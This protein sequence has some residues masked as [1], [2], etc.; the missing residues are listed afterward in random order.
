MQDRIAS[1]IC[2]VVPV[3][4]SEDTIYE[5]VRR[6]NIVLEVFIEYK[7]VL[8]DDSSTDN[9]FGKIKEIC[10]EYNNIIGITLYKNYGQQSAIMCGLQYSDCD[11]TVIIDDDLEQNPDDIIRLYKE[12]QNG[13]DV[14]Y[15]IIKGDTRKTS[16]NI[17]SLM[18][19]WLF[20]ILTDIPKGIRVSSLRIIRQEIVRKI[21][22]YDTQFVYISLEILKHTNKIANINIKKHNDSKSN[23]NLTKLIKLY[24]KMIVNYSSLNIFSKWRKYGKCYEIKEVKNGGIQ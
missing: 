19:D 23:Y 14:V 3:Y 11:F 2:V 1:S 18:R 4:N 10:K 5:L 22:N 6:L 7:I 16:R 17:G 21:I 9:S 12:I 13:Y 15:G 8:V 20:I 24:A